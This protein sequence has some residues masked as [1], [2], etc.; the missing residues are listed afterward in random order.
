MASLI[1]SSELAAYKQAIND[2]FDTFKRSITVH[3]E[4]IK[5]IL[6]NTTNQLLGYQEDSNIVDYTYTPRNQT[7]DAIIN[8][9]LSKENLQIDDEIKLKF[10]NQIV[11]IKV[12]ENAKNYIN[13][14]ITEKITFDDKTFNLISTDII[15]N[16]QGLIYYVYYLN[17]TK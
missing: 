16:Y 10:P 5:N 12:K 11:E 17:E 15:K 3:K 1:L 4:P 13:Q 2:H 14:D 7:F 9:N 8:Y 6:Q